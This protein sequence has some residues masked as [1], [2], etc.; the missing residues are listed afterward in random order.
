VKKYMYHLFF[1][2][3][4]AAFFSGSQ[5]WAADKAPANLLEDLVSVDN[6]NFIIDKQFDCLL[7]LP[8]SLGGGAPF[9]SVGMHMRVIA[10]SAG[11]ISRDFFVALSMR[12]FTEAKIRLASKIPGLTTEQ[13][14]LA[15]Q[16]R[17][18]VA[19]EQKVDYKYSIKMTHDGVESRFKNKKRGT[20]QVTSEPWSVVLRNLPDKM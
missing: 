19:P 12:M 11:L 13:T 9:N 17:E 14:L 4:L 15:M 6:S 1:L 8:L 3:F 10:P 2:I 7:S 18:V 5:A 16:C 20:E